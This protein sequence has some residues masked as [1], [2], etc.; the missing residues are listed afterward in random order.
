MH[1]NKEDG[2]FYEG[3]ICSKCVQVKEKK[4]DRWLRGVKSFAL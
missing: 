3:T 2:A 1:E 4:I